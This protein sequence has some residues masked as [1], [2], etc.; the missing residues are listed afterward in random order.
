MPM[1]CFTNVVTN[2]TIERSFP[3]GASPARVQVKGKLFLR[4]IPAEHAGPARRQCDAWP[5]TSV[6]AGIHPDQLGE[7]QEH[8]AAHGVHTEFT[9]DGDAIFRSRRHRSAH[10][11]A[12]HTKDLDAGYGDYC[13]TFDD[14][15]GPTDEGQSIFGDKA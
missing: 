2:E 4:N 11:K 12:T 8:L 5:M 14:S 15:G 13:D 7:V 10:L 1:Y 3:M 6:N 9:K